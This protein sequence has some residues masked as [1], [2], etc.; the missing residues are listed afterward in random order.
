M[1]LRWVTCTVLDLFLTLDRRK[2]FPFWNSDCRFRSI[3]PCKDTILQMK[4]LLCCT[5]LSNKTI[6]VQYRQTENEAFQEMY[7]QKLISLFWH[8]QPFLKCFKRNF[9]TP[10]MKGQ[11]NNKLYCLTAVTGNNCFMQQLTKIVWRCKIIDY[12]N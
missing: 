3:K 8:V 5:H 12:C 7:L 11:T 9:E 6:Y 4:P 10:C 1:F 2:I